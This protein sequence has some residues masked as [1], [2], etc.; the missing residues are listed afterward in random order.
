MVYMY[1][2]AGK[3]YQR[4]HVTDEMVNDIEATIAKVVNKERMKYPMQ[5]PTNQSK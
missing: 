4:V 3:F 1:H 5:K 2:S